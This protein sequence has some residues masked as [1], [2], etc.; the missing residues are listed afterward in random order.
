MNSISAVSILQRLPT[1]LLVDIAKLVRPADLL[2]LRA[3]CRHIESEVF[4]LWAERAIANRDCF[5]LDHSQ[6]DVIDEIASSEALSARLESLTLTACEAPLYPYSTSDIQ[7]AAGAG[8]VGE[9]AYLT[10]DGAHSQTGR[11]E[12]VIN[13]GPE[14]VMSY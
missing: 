1:E 13:G 4:G 10:Y 11:Y 5:V 7:L 9:S 12:Y 2:A 14:F 6:L 8:V 3:T